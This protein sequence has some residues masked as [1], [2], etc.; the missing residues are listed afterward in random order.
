[1]SVRY[2]NLHAVVTG[3]ASGIGAATCEHLLA[4][5]ARVTALD[6]RPTE[7]DGAR[8]VEVDLGDPQSIDGA[9]AAIDAPVDALF[10]I[11][12]VAQTQPPLSVLRANLL[13]FVTSPNRCWW[14]WRLVP[15]SQM[16]PP[17]PAT[18]GWHLQP[19]GDLLDTEGLVAGLEWCESRPELIGDGYFF[20]RVCDRL[21]LPTRPS[22]DRSGDS[23]EL[24]KSR[25]RSVT[26][27]AGLRGHDRYRHA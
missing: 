18:A 23:R 1:M 2:D 27:D 8:F 7:I 4:A 26:D 9:V 6:V 22:S 16:S 5:G 15:R 25:S 24:C 21:H 13:G 17:S 19:I 14:A 12:G 10:N 11:A 20:Q 3:A